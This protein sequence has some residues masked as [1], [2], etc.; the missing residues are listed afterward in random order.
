MSLR[1]LRVSV[2]YSY[3]GTFAENERALN[4]SLFDLHSYDGRSGPYR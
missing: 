4:W 3:Q 1:V 2:V